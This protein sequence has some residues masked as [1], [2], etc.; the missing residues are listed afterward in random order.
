MWDPEIPLLSIYSKTTK[1]VVFFTAALHVT[2][3][4]W[5]N[6]SAYQRIHG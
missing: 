4:T 2:A 1:A 5:S 3:E 6:L